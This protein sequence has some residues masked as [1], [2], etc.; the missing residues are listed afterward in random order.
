VITGNEKKRKYRENSIS[1]EKD[2]RTNSIRKCQY[3]RTETFHRN[4]SNL[5]TFCSEK[6]N[7]TVFETPER[8]L[9]NFHLEMHFRLLFCFKILHFTFDS[10]TA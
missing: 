3:V 4:A 7:F 2:E 5:M 1:R 6:Y 10:H 9:V 8:N